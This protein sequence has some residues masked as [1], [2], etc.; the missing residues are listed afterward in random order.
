MPTFQTSHGA[1]EVSNWAYQLQGRGGV[2][3]DTAPLAAS[4]HELVVI[5]SS[6]DGTSAG[7]FTPAEIAAIQS[8]PGGGA[9]AV[10]YISIGE[11]SDF[12]DDWNPA[13]TT[14]G[15][16]AG[17]L[18]GAAPAWLGPTNPDWPESRKV[19]YWESGWQDLVFNGSGTGR[20][21]TIVAQGFDAAY[22]DIVDAYYFWAV[23]ATAADR[24]PG[25]PATEADAAARMID[26][27]VAMT[28]QARLTNPDFFVILQ[29]GAFIID[30]LANADPVRKAALLDA[31]GAIAVEDVYL[32]NGS[33]DENNGF[34]PDADV[35]AVL[36]R[37]FLA[38]GKPVF[39]VDY[40]ND[41]DLAGLFVEQAGRDGFIAT[42]APD[43]DLD[44][45]SPPL[46]ALAEISSAAEMVAGTAAAET[47]RAA[48]GDDWIFGF[49]G[50]DRLYGEDGNDALSGGRGGDTLSGGAGNDRLVGGT[51]ADRLYGGAGRD[52]FDW[53]AL[54]ESRSGSRDTVGDFQRGADK[55]DLSG[56]D[57]RTTLS[58][59]Q[60]FR[61]VGEDGFSNR[62]GEVQF[63]DFG[64]GVIVEGDVNG[65]GRADFS[66]VVYGASALTKG[67]FV[68]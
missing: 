34:R 50:N 67:D 14:N 57:A 58:G 28:A 27:I 13:W 18:T 63:R 19:R 9:V 1:I 46:T 23:E 38:N 26:F 62:A 66:V 36:Q 16:A 60:A 11:A 54:A 7:A 39:A 65:D 31:V 47:L 44:R 41:L 6:R 8:K 17:A 64:R 48:A 25:D 29:N 15:T 22:L 3:L 45:V 37:D 59:N 52:V 43:R 68:L 40:A 55:L 5:D 61:F 35:I 53:N 49:G 42:V 32:R 20:L 30:A 51:A 12:R 2:P 4:G 24:R 21:D 33:A 56:I 10:S